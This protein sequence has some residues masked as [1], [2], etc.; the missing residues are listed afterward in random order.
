MATF[1]VKA[2]P[3]DLPL[4]QRPAVIERLAT[5]LEMPAADI[6][7]ALDR[8]ATNRFELANVARDIP[9]EVA[10]IIREEHLRLP[11]IEVV[12]EPQREY[13]YGELV[14]HVLGFTG[15]DARRAR[16][17]GKSGLPA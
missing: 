7:E 14:A 11:G 9:H 6:T 1:A 8:A 3:A 2:R 16:A 5:L 4:S 13:P 15:R 12:V 17:V 10:L